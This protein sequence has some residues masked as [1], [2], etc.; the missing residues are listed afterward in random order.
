MIV[1]VIVVLE[2]RR[3]VHSKSSD[4]NQSRIDRLFDRSISE[5]DAMVRLVAEMRHI[6]IVQS[7]DGLE[8]N[9]VL[10]RVAP[11]VVWCLCAE[12][13]RVSLDESGPK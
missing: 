3:V 2:D 9:R 4:L 7:H 12:I 13:L 6:P 5:H 8:P 10:Q 11:L 1:V